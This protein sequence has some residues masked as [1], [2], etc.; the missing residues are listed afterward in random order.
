M[1]TIEFKAHICYANGRPIQE[2]EEWCLDNCIGEFFTKPGLAIRETVDNEDKFHCIIRVTFVEKM[3]AFKFKLSEEYT[4]FANSSN[5]SL[6][7]PYGQVIIDQ[8]GAT[9]VYGFFG[10]ESWTNLT[11]MDPSGGEDGDGNQMVDF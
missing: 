9:Y 4:K 3:D 7:I 1:K 8:E 2:I 5:K 10:D 11:L 6:D